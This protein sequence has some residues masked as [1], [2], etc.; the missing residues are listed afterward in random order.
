MYSEKRLSK[1]YEKTDGKCHICGKKLCFSNYGSQ[2]KRGNWEVEHSIPRA[3]GG[4]DHLNN[5]YPACISCNRS[6][7][8]GSSRSARAKNGMARAPYSAHKKESI[9]QRNTVGGGLL[10]LGLMALITTSPVGIAIG[11]L[12]GGILGNTM[13][14]DE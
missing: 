11:T 12:A 9:K 6:K 10:G 13:N 4:T 1:I 3:E 5:L 8:R 7:G 14:P 2:G